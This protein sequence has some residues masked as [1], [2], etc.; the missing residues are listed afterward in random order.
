MRVLLISSNVAQTPYPVYP[1]GMS[2]IA[3][4]ARADGHQ[5]E[6]FDFLQNAMSLTALR[7]RL[8]EFEPAVV[9]ISIRNIDN[10]NM[11]H[12]ERY[13]DAVT[14]IVESIHRS[15]PAKVILG[16]TA[17][18][19]F[20]DLIM[21][22]TGADYGVVGEGEELFRQFLAK[23]EG[24]HWPPPG[25]VFSDRPRLRGQAIPAAAYDP[26]ILGHY[27]REGSVASLQSKRGCP[28][29]CVYCSYPVL[30]GREIRSRDPQQVVD[31]IETLAR[32][33]RAE[34]VFFTDS[35]FNDDQGEHMPVLEEMKRRGLRVPWSAFFKPSGITP[36]KVELMKEVGLRSVE[37][38]SD[39]ATDETLRGQR[40]SFV[41]ND[42]LKANR[43]FME[44][45]IPTAHYFMFGGPGETAETAKAG[46][47]HLLQLQCTV[48]F[49]FLGIRILPATELHRLAVEQGVVSADHDLLEPVY[50]ISPTVDRDWLQSALEQAFAKHRRIMFPPD[51]FDRHLRMLHKMGYAGALW[52]M[53]RPTP[54]A[55]PH[56]G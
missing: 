30:E 48:S 46:I 49:V 1:L 8:I 24:G 39:A 35:V 40:K 53:L 17:F 23:V 5:V 27:L 11:L 37:M 33:H 14:E 32:E 21:R 16:G 36:D 54:A 47:D 56:S 51:R 13:L 44:A 9:G 2:M 34:S 38:G 15:S 50:Y 26:H 31:D 3:T 19:I 43:Q 18:S 4:A 29:R 28:H 41:W 25:T 20:P 42:V 12:E 22:T 10:V 7:Q 55:K 45:G 52:E 6:F